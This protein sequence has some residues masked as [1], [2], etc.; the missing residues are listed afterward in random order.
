MPPIRQLRCLLGLAAALAATTA[1]AQFTPGNVF[2]GANDGNVY[3]VSAGGTFTAPGAFATGFGTN[4]HLGDI[5]F[6]NDA[7]TMYV[8][9]FGTTLW[10]VDSLGNRTSYANIGSAVRDVAVD[11]SNRVFVVLS[12]PSTRRLMLLHNG[13]NFTDANQDGT[14]NATDII[15][16]T[17]VTGT[18]LNGLDVSEAGVMLLGDSTLQEIRVATGATGPGAVA[19]TTLPLAGNGVGSGLT[20]VDSNFTPAAIGANGGTAV[21]IAGTPNGTTFADGR[22]FA[23]LA[24]DP[25][26]NRILATATNAVYNITAGGNFA[27]APAFASLPGSVNSSIETVPA[28]PD[29][30]PPNAVCQDVTLSLDGSGNLTVLGTDVDGGSTDNVGIT[31]R[32]V[33]PNTFDCTDIGN[34]A[35]TL[36]VSDADG[37]TDTCT[38]TV[39]VEDSSAPTV[40]TQ[41]VTVVLDGSGNGSTTAAAVNNG[42]SDNCAIDTLALDTTAF[43]C[44]DVG[45][46]T[47]TLTVTDVN[48][49]SATATAT[50]TVQDNTAP[51]VVA[52]DVTV[53]L[54]GSGNAS[55]SAAA[56][57]NGSSDN[58]GIASLSLDTT[59]FTCADLGGNTV[60]LTVTDVNG[61]SATA[62]ATVTVQ[63][64]T[65]PTAIAQDVTVMLD[66]SG[67]GSTTAGAVNNG[68]SDN[69][70]IDSLVLS[71][72][73]FTCADVGPVV[74]TLTAADAAGNTATATATVTVEDNT[75]PTVVTQDVTVVLDGSGNGSTTAAAVNNGSSD[76]CAI[77]T[78]ALDTTA[79]T[80]AD[81]G[82]NTVTLTVTD[83]NGNSATATATV[84][85]EDNIAPTAV[86][87]DVTVTLDGS[88]NASTTAAAVDNGSSDNCAVDTLALDTTDF[89]C[90]DLGGNT[91]TL[92]V[93]DVNGNSAT[94]TATV[95]VQDNTA[96]TVVAQDV[97]VTLDGSGNGSTTAAAVDNGSSDNCGIDSLTLSQTAF[98]CADV[99]PVVVTLTAADASGNSATA[100]ATVTV[101][102]NTPPTVVTQDITVQLDGSGSGSTTAA[103]VNNGSSDNCAVDTL[104]LDITSFS[105]SDVGS[106]V[107]VTL[108]VTDTTGN[109]ATGTATVTVED[110]IAP[111]AV[112][113]DV[114]VTLDG[115]G[116]GSTTAAAVDN[117]SNDACGIATLSLDTTDFT[118][119]DLGSPVTVT[120]TVEDANGNTATATAMVTVQDNTA[121]TVFTQ[122]VTVQLDGSGNGSTTAGAVD[123]GSFDNCG[124]DSLTLSP[125]DFTCA[126]IGDVTV[127]LTATDASGNS[128]TATATVT[129]EE[130]GAPVALCQDVTIFL[131]GS[132]LASV[133]PSQV[134]NGSFDSCTAVTLSLDVTD[135]D[136][137][138]YGAN[139][140]VLT[141][142]DGLGNTSTCSATVFVDDAIA[143]SFTTCPPLAV[144]PPGAVLNPNSPG[145][146]DPSLDSN[147][148]DPLAFGTDNCPDQLLVDY[149]PTFFPLGCTT[150]TVTL[151]D[152]GGNT[153][154]CVFDVMIGS[155]LG[156]VAYVD[157][158]FA[159][160][161]VLIE[162]R[163]V[164]GVGAAVFVASRRIEV[165]DTVANQQQRSILGFS[166]SQGCVGITDAW[167]RLPVEQKIGDISALG[168]LIIE[169]NNPFFGTSAGWQNSD[170]QAPAEYSPIAVVPNADLVDAVPGEAIVA[171][172]D[173]AAWALIPTN[174]N[175]QFRFR[176]ATP[177]NSNNTADNIKFGAGG[178]S[179]TQ[180][181]IRS[182]LVFE[183]ILPTE[184]GCGQNPT[185]S[186]SPLELDPIFSNPL[187]DGWITEW[188]SGAEVGFLRDNH[189]ALSEV[190][191][192]AND[193]QTKV[194]FSFDTSM[195]GATY[196]GAGIESAQLCISLAGVVGDPSALGELRIAMVCPNQR[197]FF[198]PTLALDQEDFE[199]FAFIPNA[200]ASA[201]ILPTTV[202]D[203][204]CI[205]LSPA[206][207]E[208]MNRTG[209]T[210]FRIEFETGS[211]DDATRDIVRLYTGNAGGDLRPQ[212]LMTIVP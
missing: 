63:D 22:N 6:S 147:W 87:Q 137:S 162:S 75:A 88:G 16:N 92:T 151:E 51:T 86:A 199:E 2:V 156:G 191:D 90:A 115:T 104:A 107:T 42:S 167:L 165:G 164:P 169:V 206:A 182:D 69:C 196:P 21:F 10:Q 12:G 48:G 14:Y 17:L 53:V 163:T 110:N 28:V 59:A 41:D 36:T 118:C 38:A 44:A 25:V 173:P 212:L 102:E 89:T 8:A 154:T 127:T 203:Q 65:A 37:N 145:G 67:N 57:D 177:T 181:H 103:A 150:V 144:L 175:V 54:D 109:T 62:T 105:C 112:A 29:V 124:I 195:L 52:Q 194:L 71:Q 198:G 200:A 131:D 33:S 1:Q 143:P 26:N 15:N 79:F 171:P 142:E 47:V 120:L 178:Q 157:S 207:L 114:T 190:G 161:S 56:V 128:A 70:G 39:T 210:Q 148:A 186:S 84:T 174:G 85:V 133:T 31:S 60:T 192:T 188:A 99:G 20:T 23:G 5:A 138:N 93:T 135:F 155:D 159:Q 119:A 97:T 7:T 72:T 11:A 45:G 202:G 32:I 98:T 34:Q 197:A 81:V 208:A 122:N 30:T 78:L 64:N 91:V 74:V 183:Y 166:T 117:G 58:C 152:Q 180:R 96:P 80:C 68:S 94:A 170:F 130:T 27:A 172:L 18:A 4:V 101:V 19:F 83:V 176:F 158:Q 73:A 24:V 129:V 49:N 66:G 184:D 201:V 108:T 204:L 125:T 153:S 179:S 187:H 35:V 193:Q 136:C 40:V 134:D 168:D 77:D 46:N 111:T 116:N 76:N 132:G 209:F 100:T 13:T 3:N 149:T 50:V 61:N 82:G 113:Q 189:N 9:D 55:T 146:F 211:N 95:T 139:S 106:P 185:G 123:S 126:D 121:P 160:D 43:T 205:E 141:V 140:V